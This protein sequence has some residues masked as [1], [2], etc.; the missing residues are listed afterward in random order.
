MSEWNQKRPD[1][2]PARKPPTPLTITEFLLARIA[3]DEASVEDW[4]EAGS[5]GLAEPGRM[6][7]DTMGRP[8]Y[9]PR[10]RVLAECKAKRAI[11]D[12]WS[13]QMSEPMFE[14]D[15]P[16]VPLGG[17]GPETYYETLCILASVYADH[18]DF[19]P[20]WAV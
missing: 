15:G 19:D 2:R 9:A 13:I 12:M 11:I 3:E 17:Q 6:W 8:I 4:T 18:P 20:A 16:P 10:A 14:D 7:V 1:G 5:W